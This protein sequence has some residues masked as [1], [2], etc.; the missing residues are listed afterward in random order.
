METLIKKVDRGTSKNICI[1]IQTSRSLLHC[2][3][4]GTSLFFCMG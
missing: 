2:G 4:Q 1:K 3:G